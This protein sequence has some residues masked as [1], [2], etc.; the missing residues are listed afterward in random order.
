[1]FDVPEE[2]VFEVPSLTCFIAPYE[3]E[4]N[5]IMQIFFST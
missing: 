3:R 1:M 5:F 2:P 4:V